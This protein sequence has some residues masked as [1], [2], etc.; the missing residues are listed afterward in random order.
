VPPILTLPNETLSYITD[1]V[2]KSDCAKAL[3]VCTKLYPFFAS[4]VYRKVEVHQTR[5]NYRLPLIALAGRRAQVSDCAIYT[6]HFSFRGDIQSDDFLTFP[7]LCLSLRRMQNLLDLDIRVTKA[8]SS[9]LLECMDRYQIINRRTPIRGV[10]VSSE[11]S[12][13]CPRMPRLRSLMFRQDPEM[14]DLCAFRNITSLTISNYLD[15][16]DV[17]AMISKLEETDLG[18]RITEMSLR[19]QPSIELEQIVCAISD[20]MPSLSLLCINH[21]RLNPRVSKT[22]TT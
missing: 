16:F 7:V 5:G 13:I 10:G 9:F 20:T 18:R 6:L 2:P 22:A 19:L 4:R 21:A 15:Y 11:S 3:S 8:S 12:G 17:N 14:L 1:F